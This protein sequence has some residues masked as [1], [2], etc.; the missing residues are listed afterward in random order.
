MRAGRAPHCEQQPCLIYSAHP[1]EVMGAKPRPGGEAPQHGGETPKDVHTGKWKVGKIQTGNSRTGA[2]AQLAP[3]TFPQLRAGALGGLH[4]EPSKHS[5]VLGRAGSLSQLRVPILGSQHPHHS[6]V[7]S[8]PSQDEDG[9]GS[10]TPGASPPPA[11]KAAVPDGD[12]K[13]PGH[14]FIPALGDLFP[15]FVTHFGCRLPALAPRHV[16]GSEVM[17][18]TA[19]RISPVGLGVGGLLARCHGV[20]RARG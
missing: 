18:S 8:A 3:I 19:G 5:A 15:P 9:G 6:R 16:P 1:S 10:A 17:D 4:P 14:L 12:G 20:G 2:E 7:P 13:C 11:T